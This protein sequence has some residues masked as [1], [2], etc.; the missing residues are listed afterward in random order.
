MDTKAEDLLA[1][2]TNP[3]LSIDNKFNHLV[4]IKSD[5]K[6]KNVPTPVIPTLFECMRLAISSPHTPI[7]TTAFS[8]L[9]HLLKRL[10]IQELH[11]EV[12][13]H[14]RCLYPILLERLG[15][16]KERVRASASQAL[17]D[18]WVA[19]H[20]DVEKQVLGT[21]LVGKNPRAK[22]VS[23]TWLAT[24][25]KTQ[26][27]L[28]R[29]YV[30]SVVACLEDADS[31]VRDTAKSTVVELFQDAPAHAKA[32]LKKEISEQ[33]VRKSIAN[34]V[35]TGLGLEP[36]SAT[37]RPTSRVEP[38]RHTRPA[39]VVGT[40]ESP[41]P[42][43]R[44]EPVRHS[45]PSPGRFDPA[46]RPPPRAEPMVHPRPATAVG[47][48]RPPKPPPAIQQLPHLDYG[49][50]DDG[51]SKLEPFSIDSPRQL[52]ELVK[53][54]LPDFEGRE[55]EANWM[56]RERNVISLRRITLANA[57]HDFP[58]AY[59][60]SM[61]TVIDGVFK[62]VNSLRTQLCNNGCR[63]IRDM[64]KVCRSKIDPMV[65]LIMQH[66]VKLCGGM[67]K[68]TAQV[69][70]MTVDVVLQHVSY[71]SRLLQHISGACEDKNVQLRLFAAGWLKTIITKQATHKLNVEHSGGADIIG[72]CIRRG[73]T[74]ANPGVRESMRSTFWAFARVW[75]KRSNAIIADLDP[76]TRNL[77][78]KDSS[79]PENGRPTSSQPS[80]PSSPRKRGTKSTPG[81][82]GRL[83]LKEAIAAQKKAHLGAAKSL[84][85]RPETAQAAL[86][87]L[88][89]S[90]PKST[91]SSAPVRRGVKVARPA[92]AGPDR[93]PAERH[94]SPQTAPE[95]SERPVM[96]EAPQSP[97][98]P[99]ILEGPAGAGGPKELDDPRESSRSIPVASEPPAALEAPQSPEGPRVL[100]EPKGPN[101]PPEA[102]ERPASSEGPKSSEGPEVTEPNNTQ[103][104]KT[105][106]GPVGR[107]NLNE[108]DDSNESDDEMD[109]MA[110]L[111]DVVGAG[112]E[113]SEEVVLTAE[114]LTL[115]D[116]KMPK[117]RIRRRTYEGPLDEG[118]PLTRRWMQ[119]DRLMKKRRKVSPQSQIL[120][121][122][123]IQVNLAGVH[124]QNNN[125]D[126]FG[127][128]KIQSLIAYHDDLFEDQEHYNRFLRLLLD[129]LA[130]D[131]GYGDDSD[132]MHASL[133][134]K[135][136]VNKTIQF[137]FAYD[138]NWFSENHLYVMR[139]LFLTR[140]HYNNRHYICAMLTKVADDLLYACDLSDLTGSVVEC[141]KSLPNNG[142]HVEAIVMGIRFLIKL[143]KI[144][145]KRGVRIDQSILIPVGRFAMDCMLYGHK[146]VKKEMGALFIQ[147]RGM[148]LSD[149]Q[150]WDVVGE[151]TDHLV[152][153][154]LFY[155]LG[156][157]AKL[158]SFGIVGL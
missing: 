48:H 70:N 113:A 112:S 14:G 109:E 134:Y 57:P 123:R 117:Q 107:G 7:Y 4:A 91:L 130:S 33:H 71:T 120:E 28:F 103:G 39:T 69:A 142:F 108:L 106:E 116:L 30:S 121:N 49:P 6:Q 96:L 10:Y 80:S 140:Q 65:E 150:F 22:E 50:D 145:N 92:P 84:P 27:L 136:Q 19:S 146:A 137:M 61:R 56:A 31:A 12:A 16:H 119:T 148:V 152:R 83:A 105:I 60:A 115:G 149:R 147:I 40:R 114:E 21:A 81:T 64:A 26:G 158:A 68:I 89:S 77:L 155:Y 132:R 104:S 72:R 8:T 37:S 131:P 75:S 94:E 20:A 13:S 122:A 52:E 110:G 97:E 153:N 67:K 5:I 95:A 53:M 135:Q 59:I 55:T 62:V 42:A 24:M 36:V 45:R 143:F 111:P 133:G 139:A 47:A 129:D 151:T 127:Y 93:R 126:M 29:A 58:Q 86:T 87:E 51:G 101:S 23:L 44:V 74:D 90:G 41:R 98:R 100:E 156:K 34:A 157:F 3:N 79:N 63:L 102:S 118:D 141:L 2:L 25:A 43:S 144:L 66:M 73:L 1:A 18:L 38:I 9:T 35:L 85:P 138:E 78:E 154:M 88:E 32:D 15:D 46:A 54:M 124:I 76:K 99:R 82:P 11:G 17:T 125:F 128:R